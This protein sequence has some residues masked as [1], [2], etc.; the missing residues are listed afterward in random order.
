[1]TSHLDEFEKKATNFVVCGWVEWAARVVDA[2]SFF[3][4]FDRIRFAI[5]KEKKN[6]FCWYLGFQRAILA[7]QKFQSRRRKKF[8]MNYVTLADCPSDFE[9]YRSDW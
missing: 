9:I 4:V 3:V 8:S 5:E 6:Y 7:L 1:M 2:K